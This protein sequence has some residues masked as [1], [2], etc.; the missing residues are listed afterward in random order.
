MLI[1]RVDRLIP[2]MDQWF[3]DKVCRILKQKG[4]VTVMKE[5]SVERIQDD[6]VQTTKGFIHSHSIIWTAGIQARQIPMVHD[7]EIESDERSK[8]IKVSNHLHI[9]K[10]P[11]VFV[12]GDQA[13]VYD[14]EHE[15]G[16]PQRAQFAVREGVIAG[17]NIIHMINEEKLE[18]FHWK[19]QGF[20]ISLGKGGAL[21]DI[22][23]VKISG[24]FA[25]WLYRTAY[26]SKLIGWRTKIRAIV[27][28]T[29]N[30]FLPRDISK[31]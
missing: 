31:Y 29:L 17:R 12:I 4:V 26:I 30:L 6:G 19:D 14:K 25:W 16:Y 22:Y 3:S 8:R 21:A 1:Q 18:E 5:T 24:F 13:W 7:R 2:Q 11:E 27:D 10:Y 15:Q 23:G 20:I 9:D 28:W